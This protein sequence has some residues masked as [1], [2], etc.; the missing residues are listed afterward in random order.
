MSKSNGFNGNKYSCRIDLFLTIVYH[1]FF[2]EHGEE[3]YPQIV[4]PKLPD[5]LHPLGATLKSI[6]AASNTISI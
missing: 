3:I 2:Y 6:N 4:G 1:I 5:E